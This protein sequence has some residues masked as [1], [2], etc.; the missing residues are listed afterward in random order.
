MFIATTIT[1]QEA[2][3][4]RNKSPGTLRSYGALTCKQRGVY[5][6][7]IPT[8]LMFLQSFAKKKFGL[9]LRLQQGAESL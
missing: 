2:P 4:E 1:R 9:F 3:E 6:H 7:F 5:K 8:G